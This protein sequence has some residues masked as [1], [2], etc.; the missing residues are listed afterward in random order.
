MEEVT[1]HSLEELRERRNELDEE[2]WLDQGLSNEY[3]EIQSEIRERTQNLRGLT[4][5]TQPDRE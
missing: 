5:L 4:K 3:D 1:E 2:P